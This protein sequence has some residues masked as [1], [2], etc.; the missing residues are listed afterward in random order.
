MS[1]PYPRIAII[2]M[3]EFAKDRE[4]AGR[5]DSGSY[6]KRPNLI[7][8]ENDLEVMLAEGM[9]SFHA[10]VERW[11][12]PMLLRPGMSPA[13]L[14]KL[15]IGWDFII[16]IDTKFFEYA[17][18]CSDL[19]VRALKAHGMKSISVKFSGNNGFHVGIPFEAFPKKID[20]RP[21]ASLFPE[22]PRTIALYLR[23]FIREQLADDM[24][25]YEGS[26]EKYAE[27]IGTPVAKVTQGDTINPYL[28]MDFDTLVINARHLV[29]MPFSYH[30]KSGLFSLPIKP[31]EITGFT[32]EKAKTVRFTAH[33]LKRT[34][35]E[36]D[37]SDL[38]SEAFAFAKRDEPSKGETSYEKLKFA[39]ALPEDCFP[40]CINN[41]LNAQIKDGRK[42]AEFVLRCFL[43]RCGWN[44]E[45]IKPFILDWNSR[46]PEPLPEN[47]LRSHISY[48]K[49]QNR[50]TMP[51]N[52]D[53]SA[54]YKDML[55]CE[56]ATFCTGAKNPVVAAIRKFRRMK[57]KAPKRKARKKKPKTK[58]STS[59]A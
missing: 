59:R 47:Y 17:R 22:A 48:H 37:A 31:K 34:A 50:I 16:D 38:V 8:Y 58:K 29:R 44:W 7:Q 39:S 33:F 54:F 24:L 41:I 40:P 43:S 27:K 55:V 36:E 1:I 20:G 4:V 46:L 23:E 26:A 13:E 18:L 2:E 45:A 49:K 12:R 32:K 25:R 56:P 28:A 10:S 53:N 52:C 57:L 51:P 14:N 42:R 9:Q 3:V 19:I 6:C 21:T 35:D 5:Y 15:R 11:S 30:E